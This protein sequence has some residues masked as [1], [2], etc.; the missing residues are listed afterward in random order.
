MK[1]KEKVV[2]ERGP[3]VKRV[4]EMAGTPYERGSE[5]PEVSEEVKERLMAI[6]E[7]L[8]LVKLKRHLS[9]PVII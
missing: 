6:K 3:V 7:G 4:Y 2:D 9:C 1:L 5:S 8:S